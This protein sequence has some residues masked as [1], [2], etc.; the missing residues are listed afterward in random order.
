MMERTRKRT[1]AGM[2]AGTMLLLTGCGGAPVETE[3]LNGEVVQDLATT[4][5]TVEVL[6][7][8][9][10]DA[11]ILTTDQHTVIIDCGERE[12]GLKLVDYMES[13]GRTT[14]DCLILT[15]YDQDHIGG[16][17]KVVSYLDVQQVVATDYEEDSS[18]Y[19]K[20]VKAM[21]EKGLAFTIPEEPLTFTLDDAA[22][23][24][25]PHESETYQDGFDNNCSLVT[26][27]THHSMTLLFT[28]DAMEERL[29]EIMDIGDCD[30]LKVPYH[31]REIANLPEFLDA[32]TPEHAVICTSKS[33]LADSTMEALED[34]LVETF[35]TALDGDI[36]VVS[37]GSSITMT[38]AGIE[39]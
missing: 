35:V 9:K 24:I 8:G 17:A 14:V 23:T 32:V 16:A 18:E 30:F 36:T 11:M 13:I 29:T 4:P 26:R 21:D 15:H 7:V 22:F 37:D 33:E 20:L 10:A 25:Y 2:L 1:L 28:G 5:L 19:K 6:K 39:E 31:G 3:V 38:A 27:V 34:R 12:D